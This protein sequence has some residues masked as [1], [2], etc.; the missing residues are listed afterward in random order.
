MCTN[1]CENPFSGSGDIH[2]FICD[3]RTPDYHIRMGKTFYLIE[4]ITSPTHYAKKAVALSLLKI[5]F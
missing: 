2:M 4:K 5:R 3:R 1:F